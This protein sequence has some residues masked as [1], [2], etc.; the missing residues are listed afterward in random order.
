[1]TVIRVEAQVSADEIL[2]AVEQM[3]SQDLE[4]FVTEVLK[5]RAQ[6]EVPSL[7]ISESELLVKI[8]Q[9]ISDEVQG[10]FNELVAK[11]QRLTLSDEEL[12]DKDLT[13]LIQLTDEIEHL[14]ADRIRSLGELGRL[15]RRSLSEIMQDLNICP[16]ACA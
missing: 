11:K 10:R 12:S 13:E 8:N 7:S 6:R 3:S 5:L 1:M 2:K 4:T 16:P 15:R 9:G 14:D